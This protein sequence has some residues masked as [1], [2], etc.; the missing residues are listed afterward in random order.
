L[1]LTSCDLQKKSIYNLTFCNHIY[2]KKLY[3]S[4]NIYANQCN[5]ILIAIKN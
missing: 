5:K 3:N 4:T 1:K 2:G